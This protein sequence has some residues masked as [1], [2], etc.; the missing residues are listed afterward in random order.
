MYLDDNSLSNSYGFF[1]LNENSPIY[2][3]I[4]LNDERT[5]TELLEDCFVSAPY[6]VVCNYEKQYLEFVQNMKDLTTFLEKREKCKVF[7]K[8]LIGLSN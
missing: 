3:N 2:F 5:F 7:G 8:E 1:R 4:P 6:D